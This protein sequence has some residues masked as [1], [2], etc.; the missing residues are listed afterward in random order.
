MLNNI[1]HSLSDLLH[2]AQGHVFMNGQYFLCPI[3][4]IMFLYIHIPHLLYSSTDKYLGF[5]HI[6]ITMNHVTISTGVKISLP[7]SVFISLDIYPE[8]RLL[9]LSEWNLLKVIQSCP[10]LC[11]PTIY[12]VQRIL[13]AR[14]MEWVVF[15]F[16]RGS[17]QPRDQTQLCHI[18]GRFFTSC[19]TGEAQEYWS[20]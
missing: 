2:L 7:Y 15:P 20:G 3:C 17:S 10:T 8:M 4:W 14:I 13:Q 11:Y 5:S 18:V 6:F 19:A 12:T 1:C 16:S 9:S